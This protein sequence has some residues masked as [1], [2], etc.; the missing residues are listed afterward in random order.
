MNTEKPNPWKQ[1]TYLLLLILSAVF[2]SMFSSCTKE[3]DRIEMGLIVNFYDGC[4]PEQYNTAIVKL[5]TK[6]YTFNLEKVDGAYISTNTILINRG[7]YNVELLSING[8]V[9]YPKTGDLDGA[10]V[11]PGAYRTDY[12]QDDV[13]RMQG[14]CD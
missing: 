11:H 10:V 2:L 3:D 7:V 9:T 14:F 12:F 13:I 5:N 8:L 6:E 1:A 4:Q